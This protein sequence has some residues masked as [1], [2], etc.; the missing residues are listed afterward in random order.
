VSPG[1]VTSDIPLGAT[2]RQA[3]TICDDSKPKTIF[4][5][6]LGKDRGKVMP[7]RRLS[8]ALLRSDLMAHTVS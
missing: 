5:L 6:K 7:H 3:M 2:A 4:D 1:L 8:F